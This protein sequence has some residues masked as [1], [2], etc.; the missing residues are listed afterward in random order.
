MLCFSPP[1]TSFVWTG[2]SQHSLFQCNVL[3]FQDEKGAFA[4]I[5][6]SIQEVVYEACLSHIIA[7]IRTLKHPLL[8]EEPADNAANYSS[9]IDYHTTPF[10]YPKISH[11]TDS[12][13]SSLSNRYCH[14]FPDWTQSLLSM[15]FCK[16][17]TAPVKVFHPL[18]FLNMKVCPPPILRKCSVSQSHL[19]SI[20]RVCAIHIFFFV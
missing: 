19:P 17:R 4:W 9:S 10:D 12:P 6:I 1:S 3:T 15:C 5:N 16:L 20:I 11:G 2:Q 18:R 14:L 13:V 8:L 7:V